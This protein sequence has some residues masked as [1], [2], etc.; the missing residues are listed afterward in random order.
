MKYLSQ[1][2]KEKTE[3]CLRKMKEWQESPMTL[4]EQLEAARL[5]KENMALGIAMEQS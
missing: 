5:M 2:H 4:E 1:F 3:R